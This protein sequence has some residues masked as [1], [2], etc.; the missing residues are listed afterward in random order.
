MRSSLMKMEIESLDFRRQ[1]GSSYDVAS[2]SESS[3]L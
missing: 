1:T 2:V 3:D